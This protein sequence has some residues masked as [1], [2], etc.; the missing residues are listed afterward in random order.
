MSMQ[1][2]FSGSDVN[3][4]KWIANKLGQYPKESTPEYHKAMAMHQAQYAAHQYGIEAAS[5]QA[6]LE[7]QAKQAQHG[8]NMEF[9]NSVLRHAKHETPI[10]LN[11]G[12]TSTQFT[13][14]SKQSR[15]PRIAPAQASNNPRPL[16]VR[17]PKTGRAMKA[18]E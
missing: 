11:M 16:P 1:P 3:P 2:S 13:K 9:F 8:R 15:T 5:H 4:F 6:G 14:K 12:D 7:E 17:D 10:H 18:P